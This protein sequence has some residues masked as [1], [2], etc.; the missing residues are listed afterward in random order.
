M[1]VIYPPV[2][3]GAPMYSRRSASSFIR[4]TPCTRQRPC[5]RGS[6]AEG[7]GGQGQEGWVEVGGGLRGI[8]KGKGRIGR[9]GKLERGR[10]KGGE[11][12]RRDGN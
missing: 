5:L 7:V 8:E 6:R 1:V 3:T 10:G 9:E 2:S 11:E 12:G 4:H